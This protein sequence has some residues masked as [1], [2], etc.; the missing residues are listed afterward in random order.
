MLK[1]SLDAVAREQLEAARRSSAGQLAHRRGGD[2]HVL[3][4]VVVALAGGC[5]LA[6]HA[7]PGE[8]TL[9]VLLGRVRLVAGEHAWTG[10]RRSARRPGRA[11]PS[12]GGRGRGR[13]TLCGE[14][15]RCARGLGRTVKI[16]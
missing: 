2:E 14:A 10:V 5:E 13:A 11:T 8:A 6:E 16:S 1:L 15:W 4:Q 9:V 7:N 3:R 12:R